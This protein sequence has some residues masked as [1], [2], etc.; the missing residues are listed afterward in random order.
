MPE[1]AQAS[2]IRVDRHMINPKES[3][4]YFQ[5]IQSDQGTQYPDHAE[6]SGFDETQ[7]HLYAA[8]NDE[9]CLRMTPF[10]D[11]TQATF[12]FYETTGF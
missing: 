1:Q 8:L 12:V 7:N 5:D 4:P 6:T 3:T 10:T 11:Y 2:T 9:T